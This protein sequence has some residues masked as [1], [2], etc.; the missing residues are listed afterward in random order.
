MSKIFNKE[1]FFIKEHPNLKI[2]NK[3]KKIK[4]CRFVSDKSISELSNICDKAIVPSMTS[5]GVDAVMNNLKTVVVQI[6]GQ[7]NFSPLKGVNGILHE[8]DDKMII[9]YFR[10]KREK[11]KKKIIF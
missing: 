11:N 6:D 10:N 8:K 9:N 4:N 5:A 3:L 7:I 2:G 1:I